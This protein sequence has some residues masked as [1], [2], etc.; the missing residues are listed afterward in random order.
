M[1]P[2]H[3][4]KA[5]ASLVSSSSLVDE[6]AKELHMFVWSANASP[7][8][9]ARGGGGGQLHVFG[10]CEFNTPDYAQEYDAKEVQMLVHSHHHAQ[11]QAPPNA[12][13]MMS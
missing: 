11:Y 9:E 4:A 1:D 12:T 7:I 10:G 13:G 3:S 5:S 6:N 8:S 2:P